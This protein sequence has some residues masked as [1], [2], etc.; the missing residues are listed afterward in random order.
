M[1][2][3]HDL[4][5]QLPFMNK[6]YD[7]RNGLTNKNKFSKTKCSNQLSRNTDLP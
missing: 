2:F 7:L 4:V 6:K 1:D 5:F 3:Y